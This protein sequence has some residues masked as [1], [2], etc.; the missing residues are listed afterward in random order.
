[1][2]SAGCAFKGMVPELLVSKQKLRKAESSCVVRMRREDENQNLGFSS[3]PFVLCGQPIRMPPK[4]ETLYERR[5]G[6]FVPQIT[7]HPAYGLPFGQDT[8][9]IGNISRVGNSETA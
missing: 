7:G 3:R 8:A 2:E 4:K 1:M 9:T 5:N 6:G